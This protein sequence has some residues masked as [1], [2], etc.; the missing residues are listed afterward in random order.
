MPSYGSDGLTLS[1]VPLYRP[2]PVAV[3]EYAMHK[4]QD[5]AMSVPLP[6]GL[7]QEVYEAAAR[8]SQ[9]YLVNMDPYAQD[10]Y[11]PSAAQQSSAAP[12]NAPRAGGRARR[13]RGHIVEDS[14]VASLVAA[15]DAPVVGPEVD[16]M[17]LDSM[18]SCGFKFATTQVGSRFLQARIDANDTR[19]IDIVF[20][21][22]RRAL[23]C[24]VVL[25]R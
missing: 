3:P 22:V 24:R 9:P 5:E 16:P 6:M 1:N 7:P 15:V 11:P 4:A 17:I 13:H 2:M 8:R 10:A 14:D 25:W 23:T 12:R 18:R 21:V 20:K 19:Y